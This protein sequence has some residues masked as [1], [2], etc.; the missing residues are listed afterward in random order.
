MVS[1]AHPLASV[2]GLRTLMEGG[3]AI[4]AAVAVAACPGATEMGLSGIGGVMPRN[5]AARQTSL[6]VN[7]L[8]TGAPA[9]RS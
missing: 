6:R 9:G 5:A 8:I 1:S 2:A 3:N 4:D 7:S